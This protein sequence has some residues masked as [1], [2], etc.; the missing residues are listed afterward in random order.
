[1]A[2]LH[3]GRVRAERGSE[4]KMRRGAFTGANEAACKREAVWSSEVAARINAGELLTFQ[5][6][7]GPGTFRAIVVKGS[8]ASAALLKRKY[9]PV[10]EI[11][12][13][14]SQRPELRPNGGAL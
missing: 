6:F 9:L 2:C 11:T 10:E 12:C 14:D 13:L 4:V 5:R 8:P 3:R 1:M 7:E